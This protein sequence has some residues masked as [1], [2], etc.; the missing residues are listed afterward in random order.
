MKSCLLQACTFAALLMLSPLSHAQTASQQ[1]HATTDALTPAEAPPKPAAPTWQS[2]LSF[3]DLGR[4]GDSLLVGSQPA[5]QIEFSLRGDRLVQEAR[6]DLVFTPSPSLLPDVSH[7]RVYLNEGLSDVLPLSEQD[8]G[9]QVRRSVRLDPALIADHNR[10]RLE[11]VGHYTDICED[12]THSALWLNISRASQIQLREQSLQLANDLAFFPMPFYDVKGHARPVLNLVVKG[13]ASA[14][15]QQA[16]AV[17]ASYFGSL[18]NWRQLK[19]EVSLDALPT[20][21]AKSQPPH[22]IVLATNSERPAWMADR[23]QFADVSEPTIRLLEHPASPYSKLL[24]VQGQDTEQLLTAVKVLASQSPLLRGDRVQVQGFSPL[25]PRQPYDAPNWLATNRVVSLG[26]LKQH[27]QQLQNSGL[28]VAPMAVE[29][30]LP[31]DVFVWR[32]HGI[33]VNLNYRYTPPLVSNDSRLNVSFN[34]Q[35][36]LSQALSQSASVLSQ[37]SQ[38]VAG[39]ALSEGQG[40]FFI[41]A[42]QLKD[43]NQLGFY[44][45][46]TSSFASAQRDQCQSSLPVQNQGIIDDS[47]SIDLSGLYH[48]M[49]LPDLQAFTRSGFPFSRMADLSDTLVLLPA[50]ASA[51]QLSTLYETLAMLSARTGLAAYNVSLSHDSSRLSEDKDILVLGDLADSALQRQSPEVILES[52]R[53]QLLQRTDQGLN[54]PLQQVSVSAQGAIGALTAWQSPYHTQ[55]SVLALLGDDQGLALVRNLWADSGK[56]AAVDGSVAILRDS[57]VSSARVGDDYYVGALPWWLL[58]WYHLS[59]YPGL[60]AAL[61]AFTVGLSSVVLWRSLRAVAKRRLAGAP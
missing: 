25:A 4:S 12:P 2:R 54:A 5:D 1:G 13:A 38:K 18:S 15:V 6:L 21:A 16:G 50:K 8:L 20:S 36:M 29:F 42:R 37:L 32:N 45:N 30:Q 31:P 33:E 22:V 44:F 10:V 14:G 9:Q 53:S 51:M 61:V 43:R 23:E 17:L 41:P 60:L 34:N 58:I 26:E 28:Q 47:S 19:V 55:R 35:L 39:T 56:L 7:I 46:Y 40:R 57:G 48:Y 11:F 49:R 59:Q 52:A 3:T 24:L 27:P